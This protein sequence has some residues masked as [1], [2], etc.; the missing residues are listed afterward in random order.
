[1]QPGIF[2]KYLMA[3]CTYGAFRKL[4]QLWEANEEYVQ[5]DQSGKFD[6]ITTR[7][8]LMGNKLKAFFLGVGMAPSLAI[9]MLFDDLNKL[10]VYMKG[11]KPQD[12]GYKEKRTWMEIAMN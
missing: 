9:F 7:P 8:M 5:Y 6:V 4:A 1:M 3:S 10:D 12:Y 11:H 2:E